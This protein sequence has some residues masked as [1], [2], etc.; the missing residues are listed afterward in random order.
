MIAP[1]ETRAAS[2]RSRPDRTLV[3]GFV[4]QVVAIAGDGFTRSSMAKPA[5]Q[6]I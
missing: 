4:Y 1:V 2:E 6:N 3:N 5:A